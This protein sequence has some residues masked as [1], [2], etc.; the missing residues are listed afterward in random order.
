MKSVFKIGYYLTVR[1][2]PCTSIHLHP[3][4]SSIQPRPSSIY[5]HPVHLSL[6]PALCNTLNVIWPLIS[7]VSGNSPK[8]RPNNSNLFILTE[9]WY[10]GKLGG[11]RFETAL[12]F[13]KFKPQ[14]PFLGN[15]LSKKSKLSVLPENWHT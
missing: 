2:V 11:Y 14:N 7:H 9:N 4:P 10:I 13:L 3:S 8:L 12:S 5:L 1:P 6:N 15:F